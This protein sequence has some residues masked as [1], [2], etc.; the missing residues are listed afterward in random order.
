MTR[1]ALF[2]YVDV[3]NPRDT[4]KRITGYVILWSISTSNFRIIR[5]VIIT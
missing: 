2:L 1:V 5:S 3:L 4:A